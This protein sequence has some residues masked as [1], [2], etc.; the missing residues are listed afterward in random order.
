[1]DKEVKN[2]NEKYGNTFCIKPFSEVA[3]TPLGAIKLCCYSGTIDPKEE[4]FSKDKTIKQ[5]FNNNAGLI[6]ARKDLLAGKKIK[7]CQGCWKD[8]E[9]GNKSM[10]INH[11]QYYDEMDPE[12]VQQ[13][14]QQGKAEVK[15]IDIK[16]GNKCNYACV[17]CAPDNSSLWGKE[18]QKNPIDVDLY[19]GGFNNFVQLV[20][21]PEH[22][23]DELLEIS[24]SIRRV[25]STGGEPML[26][27]GFK[28]YIKKIVDKGYAKYM[29]FKTVTNGTVDCSELLPYMNEFKRF[30]MDWSVDG[31]GEVYNYIRWPGNFNRMKRIH[32]KLASEIINN[33]Y[34]NIEITM[35]PTIQVFNLH[36]IPEIIQ[37][38]KD[39]Q[40]VNFVDFGYIFDEPSYLNTGVFPDKMLEDIIQENNKKVGKI[41]TSNNFNH[42]YDNLVSTV[43]RDQKLF[44]KKYNKKELFD[45][46]KRIAKW[47]DKSRKLDIHNHISTYK[48]LENYYLH[49][50]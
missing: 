24:K 14:K 19:Q 18:I 2:F 26:L 39:L 31:T 50:Q 45:K 44:N 46:T 34:K 41:E 35:H 11:T 27:D 20:D 30:E 28:G 33:N 47:F 15:S 12:F 23:Y 43:R 8:E 4:Y 25:K 48:E 22:K 42:S 7:Q 10:R 9:A 36:N 38:A 6:Q 21:Y 32:E 1:M 5:V 16:F 3:S 13:A 49:L 17:M 37:Y 29:N 40:V